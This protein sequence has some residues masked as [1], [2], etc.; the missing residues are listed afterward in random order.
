MGV[1]L[2]I[3]NLLSLAQVPGFKGWTKIP[4]VASERYPTTEEFL[5]SNAKEYLGL[6]GTQSLDLGCGSIPRNPFNATSSYG[7][8]I[9]PSEDGRVVYCDLGISQIPF[10]EDSFDFITAFDVVEHIQRVATI[11]G[12]T[13]YP[14][15]ELMNDIYRILKPGGLFLSRTPAYPEKEAFQDPTHVNIITEDTFPIYFCNGYLARIYG[16]KGQFAVVAQEWCRPSL[17]TLIKKI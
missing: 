1:K 6:P 15:V 10:K 17:L 8:D 3:V 11:D 4:Q 13:R 16:F 5:D 2:T 12:E 7:V 9:N 14:F